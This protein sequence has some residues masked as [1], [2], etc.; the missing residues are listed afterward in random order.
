MIKDSIMLKLLY[1]SSYGIDKGA[2]IV[3]KPKVYTMAFGSVYPHLIT[4]VEKKGRTKAEADLLIRWMTGYAQKQLDRMLEDGTDYETFI[5][6]APQLNPNRNKITGVIC[7]V[8]VED[9]EA[10]VMKEIRYLDKIIDELAK[11]KAIE[12]IMRADK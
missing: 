11:G 1:Y 3:T 2:M 4:K 9:M 5:V 10:S 6:K 7:G 12:N 8:R